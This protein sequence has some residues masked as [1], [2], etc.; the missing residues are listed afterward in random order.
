MRMRLTTEVSRGGETARPQEQ[1][2]YKMDRLREE[3][4]EKGDEG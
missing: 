2:T 4:H 1:T 3:G